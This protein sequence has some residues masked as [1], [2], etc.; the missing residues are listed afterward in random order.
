[1]NSRSLRFGRPYVVAILMLVP[2]RSAVGQSRPATRSAADREAVD[3]VVE[4]A[5]GFLKGLASKMDVARLRSEH[6]M[7]GKKFYVEYLSGWWSICQVS[8]EEDRRSIREL[9]APIVARND[10]AAYHNLADSTDDE[11]KQDAISYLNAC[12]LLREL[13][14]DT[15]AY[16]RE[17]DRVRDRML[18]P[19]HLKSRGID[20]TMGIVYRLRQ[21]G[22]P[23]G[24]GFCELWQ[25]P[26]CVTRL[27]PDLTQLD[28]DNP[29]QRT[30]VYD[31]THEIFYLTEFGNTPMQCVSAKDLEYIRRMHEA[32]IPIFVEKRNADAV[33]E[34]VMDLNYLHRTDLPVYAEGRRFL[35]GH[36]NEDGS[37]GDRAIIDGITKYSLRAN[38]KYLVDVGQYL[39][40]TSV[41]LEALCY[42][43]YPP[44]S[45]AASQAT[46]RSCGEAAGRNPG[47]RPSASQRV[48]TSPGSWPAAAGLRR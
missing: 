30:Y 47:T 19:K 1:M 48:L 21:L 25:R 31:M 4:R 8:T 26:G 40:T 32:L 22:R 11:F 6:R 2:V 41:A 45:S 7:K 33:A 3:R 5:Q 15:T 29:F 46:T 20:N 39:H 43:Y 36:Q 35:L 9:L 23:G 38:P 17:I 37:W 27:H 16:L 42:P 44:R 12:V 13:G 18:S 10:G 28:L 14:F 34:L 24:P